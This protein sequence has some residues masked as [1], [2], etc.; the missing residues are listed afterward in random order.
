MT[1]SFFVINTLSVC[2]SDLA[3]SISHC[4]YCVC[5]FRMGSIGVV[6]VL[7]GMLPSV[8]AQNFWLCNREDWELIIMKLGWRTGGPRGQLT[9]RTLTSLGSTNGRAFWST[10]VLADE[11]A[12]FLGSTSARILFSATDHQAARPRT[13]GGNIFNTSSIVENLSPA[14]TIGIGSPMTKSL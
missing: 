10:T 3:S 1:L 2:D 6:F 7:D 9:K 8:N 13:S 11:T 4:C 12:S 5:V 14:K